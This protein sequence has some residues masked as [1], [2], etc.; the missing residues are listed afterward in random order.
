MTFVGRILVVV[1]L[2]LSVFF[3]A[4]AGA[5]FTAHANWMKK[6]KDAQA[7]LS[8]VQSELA[9]ARSEMENLKT[10]NKVKVDELNGQITQL[11]GD[12]QGL[13]QRVTGLEDENKRV[14]TELDAQRVAAQLSTVE[15]Q[16][17][18]A[19]STLQRVKN[20]E[21]Y[22][23]RN[24]VFAELKA[25]EDK[26]FAMDLQRQQFE[27]KYAQLLR[28]AGT[29]RSFL[30]S[31]GLTTDT[32]QMLANTQP[33]ADVEGVVLDYRRSEKGGNEL[34]EISLG[35]DDDLRIG[36]T[37]TVYNDDKYLGQIRLLEVTPDRAVGLVVKKAKNTTI[38]RGDNVSTKL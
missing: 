7:S 24:D 31:K 16:D 3:M 22:Q 26:L 28:D 21:L 37:L 12:K 32:K 15:T 10:A 27:E 1:H 19:E 17:R 34:V 36:H 8:K 6:A 5:V 20:S 13:E 35:S 14:K 2:V 38:K 4:F 33:P 25:A 29:M 11:T 23:S 30:A 9:T 18:T